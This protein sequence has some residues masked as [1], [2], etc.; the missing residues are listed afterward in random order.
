MATLVCAHFFVMLS[1][2]KHL[3]V[4]AVDSSVALL[5]QNDNVDLH[6]LKMTNKFTQFPA[7]IDPECSNPVVG[8]RWMRCAE[9]ARPGS[10]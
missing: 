9:T 4:F 2:A 5:P 1:V 10:T 6:F 8:R 3:R 7:G